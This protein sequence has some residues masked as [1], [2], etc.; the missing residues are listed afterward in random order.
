L[1]VLEGVM[2]ET[3]LTRIQLWW[4][5]VPGFLTMGA[6]LIWRHPGALRR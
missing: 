5:V 6:F 3:P 4:G 2:P 1:F